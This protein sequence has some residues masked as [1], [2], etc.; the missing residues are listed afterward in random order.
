MKYVL[1]VIISLFSL[2]CH[3]QPTNEA[4]KSDECNRSVYI[5]EY[6]KRLPSNVCVP[7]GYQVMM[8]N[9][10][11]DL[12]N[13]AIPEV[14]M[15]LDKQTVVDGDTSLLL[16]YRKNTKGVYEIFK[17]L[18]NVYP[19][20]FKSYGLNYIVADPKLSE[21]QSRYSSAEFSEVLLKNS[22]LIIKFHSEAT[23]GYNFHFLF[24]N[25]K[26]DWYLQKTEEW[27]G[28][29]GKTEKIEAIATP[30]KEIIISDFNML[31][32]L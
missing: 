21:I 14:V 26:Q 25:Q 22:T 9:D 1:P 8:I 4:E 12:T 3:S 15:K 17:T 27:T 6:L 7:K 11:V 28:R 2:S 31:D 19:L 29:R 23:M 16:I 30:E 24:N 13:D 5:K 10:Q 18:H 20:Y 32:Y